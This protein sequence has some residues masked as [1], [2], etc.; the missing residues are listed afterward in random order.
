MTKEE[1]IQIINDAL[2]DIVDDKY[3]FDQSLLVAFCILP[4]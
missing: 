1:Q 2:A 3:S 4:L